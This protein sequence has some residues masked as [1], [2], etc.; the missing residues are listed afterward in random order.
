PSQVPTTDWH[1]DVEGILLFPDGSVAFNFAGLGLTKLDPC[2]G[3]VWQLPRMTHHALERSGRGG[4]W[5]PG[6]RYVDTLDTN[7]YPPL[8]PPYQ[9]HTLLE[10][11]EDGSVLREIPL[12]DFFFGNHLEALVFANGGQRVALPLPN[13]LHLND[14][15]ELPAEWADAFP[16][17]EAGD[18]LL[19]MRDL[20][21]VMVVDPDERLVRWYRTGP[22]IRQHDPDFHP[23][24]TI[25]VFDNHT[26][27]AGGSIFGGSRIVRIDPSTGEWSVVYGDEP[28]EFFY[29]HGRGKHQVLAN[30]NVLITEHEAGRVFEIDPS[31]EVVWEYV[32][33]YGPDE[34][35]EITQAVRYPEGYLER[36]SWTCQ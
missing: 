18:L 34:V 3:I 25:T 11:D 28:G 31:R 9:D 33:R 26:D 21:L 7:P 27:D 13:P 2:G 16:D 19:S 35:A 12:L 14:V 30:G 32:D 8:V 20:N 36:E 22:W 15:E 17:F 4:F 24:G 6:M 10:L 5:V 1:V 23:E 29:T